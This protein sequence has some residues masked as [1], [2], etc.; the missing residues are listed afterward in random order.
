MHDTMQCVCVC[1]L[2]VCELTLIVFRPHAE[3]HSA[4]REQRLDWNGKKTQ[5]KIRRWKIGYLRRYNLLRQVVIMTCTFCPFWVWLP[6]TKYIAVF[7]SCV[8][9][10]FAIS[11]VHW[12]R[13]R[14]RQT[15]RISE[16]FHAFS[17]PCDR[18]KQYADATFVR[19]TFLHS[20]RLYACDHAHCQ[21]VYRLTV[22]MTDYSDLIYRRPPN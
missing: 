9:G 10:S 20:C 11:M 18:L 21:L 22:S 2:C 5:S 15:E 1:C 14:A 4:Q 12:C 16:N 13:Q 6:Y 8:Y 3:V 19:F 17:T 7:R